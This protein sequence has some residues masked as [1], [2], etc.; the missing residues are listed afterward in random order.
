MNCPQFSD[1]GVDAATYTIDTKDPQNQ[2]LDQVEAKEITSQDS[3]QNSPMVSS[4]WVSW[5]I[6]P[7]TV[8]LAVMIKTSCSNNFRSMAIRVC[9]TIDLVILPMNNF[10]EKVC[11]LG[12]ILVPF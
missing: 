2:S 4:E 9:G 3:P 7:C 1:T 5:K 10:V 8:S 6:K 12:Y 11:H